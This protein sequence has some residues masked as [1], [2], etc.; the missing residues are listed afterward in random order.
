M[1]IFT[2]ESD[3]C[4]SKTGCTFNSFWSAARLL[5]SFTP[6]PFTALDLASFIRRIAAAVSTAA[7]SGSLKRFKN[8]NTTVPC[9]HTYISAH[10]TNSTSKKIGK[11]RQTQ[12]A[13]TGARHNRDRPLLVNHGIVDPYQPLY[14]PTIVLHNI[15]RH[16][17]FI[18]QWAT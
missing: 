12:N 14:M 17:L 8:R 6:P 3:L 16:I 10:A 11:F 13:S 1:Y 15:F 9:V 4:I 7:L 18:V 5:T 2:W